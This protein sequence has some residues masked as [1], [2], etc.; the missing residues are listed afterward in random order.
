MLNDVIVEGFIHEV[1]GAGRYTEIILANT[2]GADTQYIPVYVRERL[3]R[4]SLA[5]FVKA[6]GVLDTVRC[7]WRGIESRKVVVIADLLEVKK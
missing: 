6:V 7:M 2:R 4:E 1:R 5:K 3:N